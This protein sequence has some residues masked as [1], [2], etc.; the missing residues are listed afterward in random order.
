MKAAYI[1]LLILVIG[2]T[3]KTQD[4]KY[5]DSLMLKLK[6]IQGD[7]ARI[8]LLNQIASDLQYV[9]Q[10]QIHE[11]AV[12]ALDLSTKADYSEGVAEAFYNIGNF[13]RLKSVYDLAIDYAFKSLDLMEKNQN[14]SGT[15]RCYTL[16]GII[17]Y[18]LQ[19]YEISLDYFKKALQ[20]SVSQQD[21][22]W[23][24]GNY[25]NIGMVYEH[26]GIYDKSLDYYM[27]ALEINT[28]MN[29]KNWIATNY[30]N[31]GSLYQA[32]GNPKC[33]DYFMKRL[34]LKKELNDAAGISIS[35][36]FIGKYYNS[37]K[38][39]HHS[40]PYLLEAKKLND[41]TGSLLQTTRIAEELSYTYA[42]LNQFENAL[43]FHEMFKQLSDSLNLVE[44]TQKITRLEMQ[45][46]FKKDQAL[47]TVKNEKNSILR[48][49]LASFLVFSIT[50][51]I[52]LINRQKAKAKQHDQ[53]EKKLHLENRLLQE[54]L[55]FK[56]KLL[57]DNIVYLLTKN[58][59]LASVTE[60]L[61]SKRN[62]FNPENQHL[63]NEVILE[64]Q[65][66][67][68]N[69]LW[70]EFEVRFNQ[71]HSDFYKNLNV[72]FPH[73][74]PGE[75]KLC[76]FLRLDLTSKEIAAI[77]S[78][79]INSIETARTRLRKKLIPPNSELNLQEFLKQF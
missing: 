26:T 44:N 46:R 48:I 36:Y 52:L 18:Y 58:N 27:K 5:I 57:Q 24:A 10:E 51:T 54:E 65:Q 6:T 19:N 35:N 64:L 70:E 7:T 38:Q 40:L 17:Y 4:Q 34:E 3:C 32:M 67:L 2:I 33:L 12:Q 72:K 69:D 68:E 29:N 15:G 42:G 53:E 1:T 39:F 9:N 59:L 25:N 60:K 45:Y 49:I 21:K 71:V 13:Y 74:S 37:Q 79:N 41:S 30:A 78:Q 63:I 8:N 23:I 47:I 76:A 20:I 77:T 31:I 16:I 62:A 22:K 75:K 73:L 56:E 28:E 14:I 55:N 43:Q 11:I 61:M 50:T 66:A